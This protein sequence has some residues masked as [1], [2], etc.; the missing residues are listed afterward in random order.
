M[1][2]RLMFGMLATIL[3]GAFAAVAAPP[4]GPFTP[5]A[6]TIV[7]LHFDGDIADS[8]SNT[9]ATDFPAFGGSTQPAFVA[10]NTGFGQALEG[11]AAT[12]LTGVRITDTAISSDYPSP[13]TAECWFNVPVALQD[14]EFTNEVLDLAA[15]KFRFQVRFAGAPDVNVYPTA[16]VYN[17][18]EFESNYAR[19]TPADGWAY[20]EW[21]HFAVTYDS[22]A[23]PG[24]V[25]KFFF[26][27]T[28][29]GLL[30]NGVQDPISSEYQRVAIAGLAAGRVWPPA[31]P[32]GNLHPLGGMIDEVRL[33]STLRYGAGPPDPVFVNMKLDSNLFDSGPRGFNG[34]FSALGGHTDPTFVA[35]RNTTAAQALSADGGTVN[36]VLI[37]NTSVSTDAPVPLTAECW[38]NLPS[39]RTGDDYV[40]VPIDLGAGR[41]LFRIRHEIGGNTI[42]PSLDVRDSADN[43]EYS[44]ARITPA[45]GFSHDTWHHY[46]LTY[47]PGRTPHAVEFFFDGQKLGHD[48]SGTP[49]ASNF[50][51][52]TQPANIAG[53]AWPPTA[54]TVNNNPLIGIIDDV[55]ITE[56]VLYGTST[57]TTLIHLEFDG[58]LTDSGPNGYDG[59]LS[60]I[61]GYTDPTF[62]T[63]RSGAGQCLN[64]AGG[65]INGVVI[66]NTA[67]SLDATLPLTAEAWFK[68]PAD[69]AD[70]E[71]S[72]VV[73]DLAAGR[74]YFSV[75]FAGAP[76]DNVYPTLNI[77][78]GSELQ[79]NY[80]AIGP[81]DG[82]TYGEWH[83]FAVTYS[84]AP[85]REPP[86][87]FFFDGRRVP[88]RQSATDP[89][90]ADFAR[91]SQPGLTGGRVWQPT[92]PAENRQPL[93]GCIDD[94]KVT[95]EILFEQTDIAPSVAAFRGNITVDGDPSDWS[96]LGSTSVNLDTGGRGDLVAR[97]RYSWDDTYLYFLIE[98][99]AGDTTQQEAADGTAYSADPYNF[100]TV[101]FW[102]DLDHSNDGE[103]VAQDF[104]P[105]FGFSSAGRTDLA[106]ARINNVATFTGAPLIGASRATAGTAG[107]NDRVIEA[108]VRWADLDLVVDVSRQ[109]EGD[110]LGAVREGYEF[111]C[112]PLLIDDDFNAQSFIGGSQFTTPSGQDANSRDIVLEGRNPARHWEMFD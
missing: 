111:G 67:V 73:I 28:Q 13:L 61:G 46:A 54:P 87:Q 108:A 72:N 2:A 55:K 75:R 29:L 80:A 92:A 62:D 101:A 70:E 27:G 38:L 34:A 89:I 45:L 44:Y 35:A 14:A 25:V 17:G 37:A 9:F 79:Q 100:D 97:V 85:D 96:E 104:N 36:S 21:H 24:E 48:D 102:I 76:D 23:A 60:T 26:D 33:S 5:D 59:V 77:N 30:N 51:R 20:G 49:V 74:F 86:V 65:S 32:T 16:F 10:G 43:A 40:N 11:D 4:S 83:H 64:G 95:R 71:F 110:L 42:Y 31:A 6:D 94:V 112:E 105:W 22:S 68:I 15:G 50:R 8:G 1:N 78:T 82:W 84:L 91:V 99:Q 107:A 106:T 56:G 47:E 69:R 63:G 7:L 52:L 90:D 93:I 39:S 3:A 98:E 57:D 58:D 19:V 53:R 81:E 66:P 88:T 18:S 103:Q 109:P 41:F 12:S